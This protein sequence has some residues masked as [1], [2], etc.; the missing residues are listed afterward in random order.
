MV[1]GNPEFIAS[2]SEVWVAWGLHLWQACEVRAVL[3]KIEPLTCGVYNDFQWLVTEVNCSTLH[4]GLR[5]NNDRS[6]MD[7]SLLYLLVEDF[8]DFPW[9]LEAFT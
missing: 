5:G 2:Q 9:G 7:D 1:V 6:T 8:A 3:Q 4:L